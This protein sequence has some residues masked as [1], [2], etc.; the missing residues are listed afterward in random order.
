MA[1]F[2]AI[3]IVLAFSFQPKKEE[4]FLHASSKKSVSTAD[5]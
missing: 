2:F 5:K 3:G 1:D 4:A